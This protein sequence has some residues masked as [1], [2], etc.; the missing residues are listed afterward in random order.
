MNGILNKIETMMAASAFAEEG[1]FETA[2]SMMH[3]DR[4]RKTAR[5]ENIQRQSQR[6]VVRAD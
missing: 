5:P 3:E 4:K 6:K 2:R 1:E